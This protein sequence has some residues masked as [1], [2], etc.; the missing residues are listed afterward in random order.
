MFIIFEK[1]NIIE[2]STVDF[3][4]DNN[5][6]EVNVTLLV[7][8]IWICTTQNDTKIPEIQ[9][10]DTNKNC[11]MYFGIYRIIEFLLKKPHNT[12]ITCK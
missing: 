11:M 6:S 4:D 2:T 3:G 9:E 10:C 7:A 5:I 8:N 12:P 1:E